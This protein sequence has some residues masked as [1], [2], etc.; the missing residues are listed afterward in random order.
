MFL[1]INFNY[2][3]ICLWYQITAVELTSSTMSQLDRVWHNKCL[4]RSMKLRVYN[5]CVTPG[6]RH[7]FET[8]MLLEDGQTIQAVNANCQ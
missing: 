2:M 8:W 5:T 6:L 4:Q 1:F 7:A 3:I